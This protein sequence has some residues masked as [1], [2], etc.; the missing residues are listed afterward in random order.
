MNLQTTFS[1]ILTTLSLLLYG[2]EALN[3]GYLSNAIQAEGYIYGKGNQRNVL[4][5]LT[6]IEQYAINE[7]FPVRKGFYTG[8][9][10]AIGYMIHRGHRL[11]SLRL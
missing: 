4:K 11:S 5:A 8:K 1:H 2:K 10:G 3:A 6:E 7:A 9:T